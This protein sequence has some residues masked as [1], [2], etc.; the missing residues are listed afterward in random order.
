V[1]VVD[2]I[3]EP[4]LFITDKDGDRW[5]YSVIKG[6]IARTL[7]GIGVVIGSAYAGYWFSIDA[8]IWIALVI[9]L[10]M[11]VHLFE[12]LDN[13]RKL[14]REKSYRELDR[15]EAQRLRPSDRDVFTQHPHGAVAGDGTI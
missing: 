7:G 15:W 8:I 14:E 5:Y 12:V 11:V 6:Q 2:D 9:G 13:Y 3:H 4:S 10:F 1:T